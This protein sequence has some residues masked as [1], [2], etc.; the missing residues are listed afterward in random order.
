[1]EL[2]HNGDVVRV[3]VVGRPTG[4][5]VQ[6]E[7]WNTVTSPDVSFDRAYETG[8]EALEIFWRKVHQMMER[9]QQ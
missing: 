3:R 2:K 5:S 4:W 6:V 8:Q 9:M 7:T 1:M